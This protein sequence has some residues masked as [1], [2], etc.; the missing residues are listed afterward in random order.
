M[1]INAVQS[2]LGSLFL[3]L[4]TLFLMHSHVRSQE[5]CARTMKMEDAYQ[6]KITLQ[7]RAHNGHSNFTVSHEAHTL[8]M[9]DIQGG[10][11]RLQRL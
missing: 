2:L 10:P 9:S 11:E 6:T 8:G 1:I 5:L 3:A 4:C 7:S